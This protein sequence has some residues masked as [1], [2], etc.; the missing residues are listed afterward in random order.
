LTDWRWLTARDVAAIHAEL[1]AQFW[2]PAGLRDE[3]LLESA[4]ARPRHVDGY[5][6]PSVFELAAAYAFGIVRNYPFVDGNKRTALVASFVFLELNGWQVIAEE[7]HSV[8]IFRD[9]AAGEMEESALAAWLERNIRP[10]A[11]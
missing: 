9:L 7:A 8:L 11:P 1:L 2:G 10:A 3:G 6:S 5:G 4:V